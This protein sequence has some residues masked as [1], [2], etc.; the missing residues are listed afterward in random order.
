VDLP[1]PTHQVKWL[2]IERNVTRFDHEVGMFVSS[3]EWGLLRLACPLADERHPEL[4]FM[5]TYLRRG[6]E[7]FIINNL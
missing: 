3:D 7:I 5:E 4:R 1:D 2:R 6:A